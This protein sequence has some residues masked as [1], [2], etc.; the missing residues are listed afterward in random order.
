MIYGPKD[1]WTTL[2]DTDWSGR[3]E[4]FSDTEVELLSVRSSLARELG[5]EEFFASPLR[6]SVKIGP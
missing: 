2:A 1:F 4:A 6:L 3:F 5:R